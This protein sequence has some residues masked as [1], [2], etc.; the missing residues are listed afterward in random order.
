M[1]HE[2]GDTQ[3]NLFRWRRRSSPKQQYTFFSSGSLHNRVRLNAT[4]NA[5]PML[6]SIRNNQ[7]TTVVVVVVVVF[8]VLAAF[9]SSSS[10][11]VCLFVCLLGMTFDD[12]DDEN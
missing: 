3:S 2:I 11:H 5:L 8:V 10:R 6:Q 1:F 9:W 4:M 12:D 7:C